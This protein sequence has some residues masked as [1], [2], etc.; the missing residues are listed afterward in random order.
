MTVQE[1]SQGQ[2]IELAKVTIT[3]DMCLANNGPNPSFHNDKQIANRMGFAEAVVAGPHLVTIVSEA[4]T[5]LLGTGWLEGGKLSLRFFRPVLANDTITIK[6]KVTERLVEN[7]RSL[8][9]MQVSGNGGAD[10]DV[11][12]SGTATGYLA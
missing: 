5:D 7:G 12:F 11:R 10:D 6:A 2:D 3:Y 9:K 4:L 1:I 8:V